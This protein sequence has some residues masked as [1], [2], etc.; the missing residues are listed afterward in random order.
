M[1]DVEEF[2]QEKD[3]MDMLPLLKRGARVAQNPKQFEHLEGLQSDEID[4][5]RFETQHKWTH[6]M[7]LYFTIIICSIGAAVQ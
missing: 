5:L 3:L 4:A 7:A 1:L 2:A 6:P